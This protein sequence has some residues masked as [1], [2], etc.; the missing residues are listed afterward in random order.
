MLRKRRDI[1]KRDRNLAASL[2]QRKSLF[3]LILSV[4]PPRAIEFGQKDT[5]FDGDRER[6]GVAE[7]H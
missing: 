1:V 6:K 7:V 5:L 3:Y 4:S 2:F